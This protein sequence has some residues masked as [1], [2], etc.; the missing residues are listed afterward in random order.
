MNDGAL[1][2]LKQLTP[3]GAAIVVGVPTANGVAI[4]APV[5]NDN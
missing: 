5:R 2:F 1:D 3:N 4:L